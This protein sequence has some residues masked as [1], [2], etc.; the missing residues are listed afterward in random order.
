[1]NPSST[2]KLTHGVFFS[3]NNA[4]MLLFSTF[5]FARNM[6][7]RKRN[8]LLSFNI[9]LL[10]EASL[11]LFALIGCQ[12]FEPLLK[13][14]VLWLDMI[15][16]TITHSGDLKL[17]NL[18]SILFLTGRR[19]PIMFIRIQVLRTCLF[20]NVNCLNTSSTIDC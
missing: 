15:F 17:W 19:C 8:E 2:R 13:N 12:L 1:M 16:Q 18:C 7:Y 20:F 9:V 11:C 4:T 6:N 10:V 14:K 3:Y 5:S